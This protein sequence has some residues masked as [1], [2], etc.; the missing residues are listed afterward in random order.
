M[1]KMSALVLAAMLGL[2][3]TV[4]TASA[5]AAKGQKLYLKFMKGSTGLNGGEFATQQTMAEWKELCANSGAGLVDTYAAKFPD[6]ADF[7][8][9]DRFKR[10][11]PDICDFLIEYASDSGNVPAC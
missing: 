4:S 10:F 1:R 9:G 2:G 3:L 6:A 11:Q 7:L 8:Q 5:D